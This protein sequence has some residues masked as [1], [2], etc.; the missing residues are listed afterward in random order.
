M[1][2]VGDMTTSDGRP[3]L[4]DIMD[5]KETVTPDHHD[6]AKAHPRPDED[7]L[8][9]RIEQEREDVGADDASPRGHLSSAET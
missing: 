5:A 4:D 6:H 1:G 8:E 7:A 3:I 9:Q 2:I